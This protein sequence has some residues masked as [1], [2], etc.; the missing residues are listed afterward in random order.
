MC[1]IYICKSTGAEGKDDV[2]IQ[3]GDGGIPIFVPRATGPLCRQRLSTKTR[4]IIPCPST[5]N[6]K[7]TYNSLRNTILNVTCQQ[8]RLMEKCKKI[9]AKYRPSFF[10]YIYA[11]IEELPV[12]KGLISH[13]WFRGRL[14]SPSQDR[15]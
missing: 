11:Q 14:I 7:S 15:K 8:Y 3:E 9:F 4:V 1:A 2:T 6:E 13:V 12:V 5:L 10:F